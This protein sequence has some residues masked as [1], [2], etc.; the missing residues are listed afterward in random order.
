MS[1][2]PFDIGSSIPF[3]RARQA[4]PSDLLEGPACHVRRSTFDHPWPFIGD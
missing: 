1:G 2:P 4:C 3:S